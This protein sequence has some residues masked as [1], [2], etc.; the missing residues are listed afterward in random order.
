MSSLR[1]ATTRTVIPE[2]VRVIDTV[3]PTRSFSNA[4]SASP[5]LLLTDR[6]SRLRGPRIRRLLLCGWAFILTACREACTP[7]SA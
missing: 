2:E 4:R 3:Y 6:M 1:L 7:L 5:V